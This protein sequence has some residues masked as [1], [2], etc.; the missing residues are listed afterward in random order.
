[1]TREEYIKTLD[2]LWADLE[3][4]ES[5]QKKKRLNDNP[6]VDKG[7]KV[8]DLKPAKYPNTERIRNRWG[9]PV[10]YVYITDLQDADFLTA[11]NIGD[12]NA[13]INADPQFKQYFNVVFATLA[14]KAIDVVQKMCRMALYC[15]NHNEVINNILSEKY[16]L[17]T[18]VKD[19]VNQELK[20]LN[21]NDIGS[22]FTSFFISETTEV[23]PLPERFVAEVKTEYLIYAKNDVMILM[24]GTTPDP[25]NFGLKKK[26]FGA[27]NFLMFT[28]EESQDFR[29]A[30]DEIRAYL[31]ENIDKEYRFEYTIDQSLALLEF[32]RKEEDGNE[33]KP[34]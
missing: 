10:R 18:A 5:L 9:L 34:E 20:T 15:P 2:Q 7:K 12:I 11:E 19:R 16:P 13:Q 4:S 25:E 27:T 23:V 30:V 17:V 24:K 6:Y 1:M 14:Q 32:W 21:E 26:L 8:E 28:A 3:E 31:D 33:T 22:I 29:H